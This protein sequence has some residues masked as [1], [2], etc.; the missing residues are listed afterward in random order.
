MLKGG[1]DL[2]VEPCRADKMRQGDDLFLFCTCIALLYLLIT[3]FE[4]EVFVT[5]HR[6]IELFY[7]LVQL[8]IT[9]I[10]T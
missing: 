2:G 5:T 3:N 10:A 9:S 1:W 8:T 4:A 7:E 6:I